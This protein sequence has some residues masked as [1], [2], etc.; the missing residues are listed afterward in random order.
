M[1]LAHPCSWTEKIQIYSACGVFIRIAG[2]F[3]EHIPAMW[4]DFKARIEI[5]EEKPQDLL[6]FILL[7]DELIVL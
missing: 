5:R 3:M 2:I 4:T 6:I 7:V 1:L